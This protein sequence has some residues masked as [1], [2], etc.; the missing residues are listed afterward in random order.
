METK[1]IINEERCKSCSL[2]VSVCPKNVLRI[3][4]RLN[5]KGYHPAELFNNDECIS[6]GFCY[7][8]CPDAAIVE[9]RRP[10]KVK[11]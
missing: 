8:I 7:L 9:V 6:C 1:V 2:C 3:S 11:S 10:I 5:P 4:N